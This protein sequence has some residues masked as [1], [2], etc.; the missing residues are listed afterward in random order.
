ML[1][2]SLLL[3]AS[4]R[5]LALARMATMGLS[6]G[7][8]RLLGVPELLPELAAAGGGLVV[9]AIVILTGQTLLT[10]RNAARSLRL[11]E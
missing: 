8:A 11:G 9:L 6:A 2:L 5:R 10:D 7:Q 3:S 4:S 1:L